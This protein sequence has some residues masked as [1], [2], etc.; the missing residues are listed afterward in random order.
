MIILLI[1]MAYVKFDDLKLVCNQKLLDSFVKDFTIIERDELI[2][3]LSK[4]KELEIYGYI[5]ARYKDEFDKVGDDRS[6]FFVEII[7]KLVCLELEQRNSMSSVSEHR[8]E[9]RLEIMIAVKS[10]MK[11][12]ADPLI[13]RKE[14]MSND[15]YAGWNTMTGIFKE[16]PV[17]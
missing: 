10:F 8:K 15:D 14:E 16:N 11:G 1:R 17:Y 4:M 13:E 3:T 9:K 5:Q 7:S 6:L 12:H 2:A